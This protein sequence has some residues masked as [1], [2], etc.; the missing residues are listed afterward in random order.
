MNGIAAVAPIWSNEVAAIAEAIT[1]FIAAL[2]FGGAVYQL[3]QARRTTLETR[4]H[5]Y[6]RRYGEPLLLPYLEKAHFA[7]GRDWTALSPSELQ[8][9]IE[10]WE[11]LS[12][13]CR[14][15]V[16]VVLNFWE[17]LAGMYNREL[18]DQQIIVDYFGD[19]AIAFWERS[20]WLA[21]H[22]RG[23]SPGKAIYNEWEKMCLDIKVKR[24]QQRR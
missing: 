14:I 16:L 13:R 7:I 6:L 8:V 3:R 24:A 2:A 11:Q 1:A 22:L 5:E 21:V 12:F 4:A 10:T 15:D 18:V 20:M 19:A 9:R 17:E 23:P